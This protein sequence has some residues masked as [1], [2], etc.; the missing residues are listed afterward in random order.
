M[1]RLILGAVLGVAA[2][3][4]ALALPTR[5]AAH[6][7]RQSSVPT[8]GATLDTSPSTVWI[9]FGEEPDPRL[10]RIE[11]LD[12]SGQPHQQGSVSALARDA[13]TLLVAVAPLP[14]GVY[15]V[16][17][18]TVSRVDGHSAAGTFA[19][20]VGVS[21][22]ELAS[23]GA[24]G[25]APSFSGDSPQPSGWAIAGRWILYAGLLVLVGAA[26]TGSVVFSTPPRSAL[27]LLPAAWLFAVVG[28]VLIVVAQARDAGVGVSDMFDSSI[29]RNLIERAIPL[30]AAAVV[31]V[32]ALRL[33]GVLRRG[34]VAALGAGGAAALLVDVL[35]GHAAAQSGAA[36]NVA[37]QWVHVLAVG[38]WIGGLAALL[39]GIRGAPS[40]DKTRAVRRFSTAAGIALAAVAVTGIIRAVVEIGAWDRLTST[41]FGRFVIVKIGLIAVLMVLAA[42]NRY[43]NVAAASRVLRGLRRVGSAEIAVASLAVLVTAALVNVTPPSTV[44]ASSRQEA[45]PSVLSVDGSDDATTVRVHLDVSPGMA[46]FNRFTVSVVDYDTRAPV[47][48]GGVHLRFALNSSRSVGESRLDLTRQTAGVYSATGSNLSLDGTWT[49]TVLVDRGAQSVE[50]PLQVTPRVPP[51]QVTISRIPGEPTLYTVHLSA[52]RIVQ[53]YLDPDRPG[54]GIFH[55]TF[56]DASGNELPV[57]A[58]TIA[59]TP[60][61]QSS[62]TTLSVRQLEPGHFVADVVLT[63]GTYRFDVS[64]TT[65]AGET[66]TAHLDLT[67]GTQ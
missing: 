65:G 27:R 13:R 59:M 25:E 62:P 60:A 56:F 42:V 16:S 38:V 67:P 5:V 46:G 8:D 35:L 39:L 15:T 9:T 63:A 4:A 21:A 29:G 66:L 20:G 3:G 2:L 49:V 7:L 61:G 47:D 43:R 45:A 11:V 14:K 52:G 32:L 26:F 48:A 37:L 51:Q 58:A 34:A 57:P 6:A 64:G 50:V 22:A 28:T 10:S 30:G 24:T 40:A 17:W 1:R 31:L 18:R 53:V 19:F 44:V 41:A 23:L 36:A 33:R 54:A 55:A 12:T